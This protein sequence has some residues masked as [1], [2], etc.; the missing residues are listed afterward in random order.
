MADLTRI[1]DVLVVGGGNAALC[2]ALAAREA[3]AGVLLLEHAPRSF[4]G[5]NSRHTR[6]LRCMHE[7]PTAFL[8]GNYPEEEFVGDLMRVTGGATDELLARLMIRESG[9]AARWMYERGVRFQYIQGT[10]SLA[11]TNPFFLGGGTALLNAYYR[12][13]KE[14]GV[15]V[16]Y[17]TAGLGLEIDGGEFRAARVRR[18]AFPHRPRQ[19]RRARAG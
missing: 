14:L 12:R 4:R 17:D 15:G 9:N 11:R 5:G 13:A 1:Y 8:K 7:G 3:G 18:R 2:A 19:A 16:L 10:L 6:N